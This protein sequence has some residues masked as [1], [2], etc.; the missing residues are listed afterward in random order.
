MLTSKQIEYL[1][2]RENY[3]VSDESG[4]THP[5]T[6]E[7][8]RQYDHRL[9]EKAKEMIKDLTLMAK[10]LPEDQ[11]AQ[12]FTKENMRDFIDNILNAKRT[13]A[14]GPK[15]GT[16]EIQNNR[17]FELGYFLAFSGIDIAYRNVNLRFRTIAH[18]SIH[19]GI[20]PDEK[21]VFLMNMGF[22]KGRDI[23]PSEFGTHE[24][25]GFLKNPNKLKGD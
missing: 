17:A 12:T 23:E 14:D 19:K 4:V 7:V 25:S 22:W 3:V 15:Y 18:G 11:M 8:R 9:R 10:Y 24:V 5:I 16:S 21:V 20:K 6:D 13:Y 1:K 2:N